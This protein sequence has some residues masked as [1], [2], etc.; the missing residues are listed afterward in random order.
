M[1]ARFLAM[2]YLLLVEFGF[3]PNAHVHEDGFG[4]LLFLFHVEI[5]IVGEQTNK[6]YR[7]R[8]SQKE[9]EER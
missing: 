8:A 3:V 6:D 2:I 7:W 1:L 5:R 9:Q 4:Y